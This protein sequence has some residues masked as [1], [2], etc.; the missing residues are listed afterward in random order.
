MSM[1][2]SKQ[3]ERGCARNE[4]MALCPE[5]LRSGTMKVYTHGRLIEN[6]TIG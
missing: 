2:N 3:S 4:K 6:D 1:S 5:E